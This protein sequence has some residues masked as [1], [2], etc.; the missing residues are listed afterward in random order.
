WEKHFENFRVYVP[1]T[2]ESGFKGIVLT[3][4][5]TSGEYGYEWEIY[6]DVLD[7]LPIRRVYPLS[8]Y[9]MLL[10]AHIEAVK[11]KTPLNTKA[12]VVRYAQ[13]RFGLN[14][15]QALL[16]QKALW[17]NETL[18]QPKTPKKDRE[19]A[20][21]AA[22]KTS[23]ILHALK[24]IRNVKELSHFILMA[25]LRELSTKW[26]RTEATINSKDFTPAQ[27]PAAVKKLTTLI[28][29][30]KKQDR[31]FVQLNKDSLYPQQLEEEIA[32][33]NKKMMMIYQRLS[34]VGRK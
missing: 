25:D 8:G 26:R 13:E 2:K 6:G 11:S 28:K 3:S 9:R 31:R 27:V 16:F 22:V 21:E 1:F 15:R 23:R 5:S 29:E 18:L 12:F 34:R 33:R 19:I 7:M 17:L 4:W 14:S 24:P 30:S 32:Y 20:F 10:A